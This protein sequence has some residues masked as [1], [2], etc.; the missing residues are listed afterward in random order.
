MKVLPHQSYPVSSRVD[1]QGT[2]TIAYYITKVVNGGA[3]TLLF[4]SQNNKCKQHVAHSE[5]CVEA[6]DNWFC[7]EPFLLREKAVSAG[8]MDPFPSF[9][10]LWILRGPNVESSIVA[11]QQGG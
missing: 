11:V 10:G 1:Q 4:M 2:A 8:V 6:L 3:N 7:R 5:K 9:S